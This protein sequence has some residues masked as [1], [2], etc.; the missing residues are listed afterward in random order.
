MSQNQ[1]LFKF[2]GLS[3]VSDR[4]GWKTRFHVAR[5]MEIS[6]QQQIQF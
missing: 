5:V 1:E 4:N 2:Q 6:K 3:A